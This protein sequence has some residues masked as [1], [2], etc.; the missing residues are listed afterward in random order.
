MAKISPAFKLM[1][2]PM[3][4]L[5]ILGAIVAELAARAL[6]ELLARL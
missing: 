3:L 1:S 6:L 5:T 4:S 2:R